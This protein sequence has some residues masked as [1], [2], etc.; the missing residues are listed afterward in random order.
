MPDDISQYRIKIIHLD[1]YSK[2][3]NLAI[4]LIQNGCIMADTSQTSS[5][6]AAEWRKGQSD[7]L[8]IEVCELSPQ[9]VMLHAPWTSGTGVSIEANEFGSNNDLHRP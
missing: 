9:S 2:S 7:R 3:V 6:K 8:D 4:F 1:L 5:F